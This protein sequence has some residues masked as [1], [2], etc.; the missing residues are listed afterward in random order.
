[1]GPRHDAARD[2]AGALEDASR[3]ADESTGTACRCQHVRNFGL[4]VSG[5]E[6]IP[7]ERPN[8]AVGTIMSARGLAGAGRT[9]WPGAADMVVLIQNNDTRNGKNNKACMQTTESKTR[10]NQID[11]AMPVTCPG[12]VM[13]RLWRMPDAPGEAPGRPRRGMAWRGA[14]MGWVR[15]AGGCGQWESSKHREAQ[16]PTRK[17]RRGTA[18]TGSHLPREKGSAAPIR[19]KPSWA[20]LPLNPFRASAS[21]GLDGEN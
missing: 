9:G 12:L 13:D 16:W 8:W 10:Q 18:S 5:Q 6:G 14:S 2:G 21:T 1:M 7:H 19:A 4:L 20:S 17:A 3:D 15:A 11:R